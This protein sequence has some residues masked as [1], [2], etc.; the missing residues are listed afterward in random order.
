MENF[1]V[2]DLE[3][4][5]PLQLM[6]SAFQCI[7]L[8]WINMSKIQQNLSSALGLG[9][10]DASPEENY[11]EYHPSTSQTTAKALDELVQ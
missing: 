4:E 11:L 2:E 5:S 8:S 6:I 3:I 1:L 10:L 9:K 7:P